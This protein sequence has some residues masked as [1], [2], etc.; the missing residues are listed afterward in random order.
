[1]DLHI[2]RLHNTPVIPFFQSRL[3]SKTTRRPPKEDSVTWSHFC[4]RLIH[5]LARHADTYLS[6]RLRAIHTVVPIGASSVTCCRSRD[7]DADKRREVTPPSRSIRTRHAQPRRRLHQSASIERHRDTFGDSL[8]NISRR[9]P[10]RMR[11]QCMRPRAADVAPNDELEMTATRQTTTEG[12]VSRCRLKATTIATRWPLK[13]W[14]LVFA[15][16]FTRRA[17]NWLNYWPNTY[18]ACQPVTNRSRRMDRWRKRPWIRPRKG[19]SWGG[20]RGGGG[21]ARQTT[22]KRIMLRTNLLL[23][24]WETA[25]RTNIY[26][27]Y[28]R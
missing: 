9:R 27:R 28:R 18:Y 6:P 12:R 26:R 20:G 11:T 1:M 22:R 13:A 10:G 16:L 7:A 19:T 15:S 23:D 5:L 17:R 24:R 3:F 2:E 4:S 14:G 25:R 21:G 8:K